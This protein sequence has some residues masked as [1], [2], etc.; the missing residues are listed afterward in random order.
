MTKDGDLVV[1]RPSYSSFKYRK[2]GSPV[3]T[4]YVLYWETNAYGIP[5][6]C[7]KLFTDLGEL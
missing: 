7:K 6:E 4:A 2:N 1:V 5:P 3:Q